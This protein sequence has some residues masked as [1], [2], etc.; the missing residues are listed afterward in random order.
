LK[1]LS[2]LGIW[3]VCWRVDTIAVLQAYS[4]ESGIHDSAVVFSIAGW[5][6]PA[7]EWEKFCDSW[8]RVLKREGVKKFHTTD[9]VGAKEEFSDWCQERRSALVRHLVNAVCATNALGFGSAIIRGPKGKRQ[10][11]ARIVTEEPYVSTFG[12][13]VLGLA[14]RAS[15]FQARQKI[16]FVFDSHEEWGYE[17]LGLYADM[18]SGGADLGERVQRL[19][20]AAFKSCDGE[21]FLPLHTADLLAWEIRRYLEGKLKNLEEP[22]RRSLERLCESERTLVSVHDSATLNAQFSKALYEMTK[23]GIPF[24]ITGQRPRLARDDH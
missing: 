21:N 18:K 20:P 6:A 23:E 1:R 9:C 7:S 24:K 11:L 3:L 10:G 19:G 22:T 14:D 12:A 5:I 4:D 17:A 8:S 2:Q 16:G 15:A 13:L